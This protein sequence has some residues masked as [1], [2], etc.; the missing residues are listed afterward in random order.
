MM[1][2]KIIIYLVCLILIPGICFA[3]FY[4]YRDANGVLRFTDNL[5]DVPKDQREKVRQYQEATTPEPAVGPSETAPDLSLN[6]RANL[7]NNE[8]NLLAEEYANLEK[9][10]AAIEKATRDPENTAEYEAYLNQIESY[11]GKIKA[12]EEKRKLFQ[13]KVDAFNEDAKNQ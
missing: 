11:N 8:R 5:G 12:Y 6:D 7:L 2:R 1:G 9:E 10:R 4:K 3:E 13:E